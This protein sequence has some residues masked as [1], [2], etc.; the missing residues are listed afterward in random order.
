MTELPNSEARNTVTKETNI[1]K[2]I[3][4]W[5][6]VSATFLVLLAV[7]QKI[8]IFVRKSLLEELRED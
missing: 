6:C 2:S 1:K 8:E 7:D 4:S 5:P 3:P